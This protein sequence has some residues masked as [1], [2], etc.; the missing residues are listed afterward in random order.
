MNRE[1]QLEPVV[2]GEREP[3]DPSDLDPLLQSSHD[4]DDESS[5]PA[6]SS[7][8]RNEDIENGSSV[9]CCRI[10]LESDSDAGDELISPCLCKGTQQFVH[11]S[12]LDHWRSV[13]E[14]FAFSHCTTCKAQFH[15]RV[16]SYEDN[17][18]RK[19]K[20]RIFVARD[21]I[22]VFV[23]VQTVIAAIG[24]FA[25]LMDKDGGFR[26][27]FSDGWDRILSKHPIPFYYC[28]G[29][30]AFFVL[31]GFFG[32]IVHCSSFNSNDPRMAGCQNCCYG[33]GILDCFPASMEACFALVIVFVVIFAILGIAYGFLAATMAIQRIWQR[34][35]H[36]LTK[37]ELT[38]EYVVEDLHGCYTPPKLDPEHEERLKMLKLL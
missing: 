20:F 14:G 35:Y 23:A 3:N 28:I 37:K 12:C 21:V 17:T 15:L 2:V 30:I 34:H 10:C 16:E 5:A 4:D 29:V 36:I 27:S 9:A 31:L 7:E 11:I 38:K 19:M 24:G 26:N 18:W 13:K 32:L 6:S 8:I 33:W 1:V 25:Y 22:L